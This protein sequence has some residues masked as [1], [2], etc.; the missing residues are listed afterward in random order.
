MLS[1]PGKRYPWLRRKYGSFG[2]CM[3]LAT[4]IAAEFDAALTALKVIE[5]IGAQ[6]SRDRLHMF[7]ESQEHMREMVWELGQGDRRLACPNP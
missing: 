4:G 6:P 3:P 2:P 1:V 7:A 5:A